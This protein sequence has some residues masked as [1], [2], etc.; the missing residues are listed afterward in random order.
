MTKSSGRYTKATTSASAAQAVT[1]LLIDVRAATQGFAQDINAMRSGFDQVLLPGFTQAGSTLDTALASALANGEAG[2]ASLRDTALQAISDIASATGGA[3][4]GG[5]SSGGSAAL[6]GALDA[7]SG[8]PGRATGG[9]VSPGQAYLVG[10]RGPELFVPTAAGSV[11][12]NQSLGGQPREVRVS[13]NVATP[14]GSDS[15]Q[16]LQRS[17]R[18]IASAVRRALTQL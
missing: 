15:A 14:A 10:E 2:F 1:S 6:S 5:A 8:L 17:G 11:A 18:Q 7:I 12:S 13:I 9:P 16:S 3:G 4:L